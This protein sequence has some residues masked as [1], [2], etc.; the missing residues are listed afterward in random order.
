MRKKTAEECKAYIEAQEWFVE[1]VQRVAKTYSR[2]EQ[3]AMR[4]NLVNGIYKED[5]ILKA[6]P[7]ALLDEEKKSYWIK[8]Y[9]KM[10]N[11]VFGKPELDPDKEL[12]PENIKKWKTKAQGMI[13]DLLTG[14]WVRTNRELAKDPFRTQ[15]K[16]LTKKTTR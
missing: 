10:R 4:Q 2:P 16:Y 9:N 14:P 3:R 15:R 7:L 12:S 5:T 6:F 13:N 8:E 11:W 1:F